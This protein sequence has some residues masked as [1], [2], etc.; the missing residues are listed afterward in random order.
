MSISRAGSRRAPPNKSRVAVSAMP[1][2]ETGAREI[3]GKGLTRAPITVP[4]YC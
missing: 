3:L 2:L 1:F 4:D